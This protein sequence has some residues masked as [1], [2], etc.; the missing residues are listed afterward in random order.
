[1]PKN[2]TDQKPARR[3]EAPAKEEEKKEVVYDPLKRGPYPFS[4]VVNDIKNR[5][6]HY[7]T[8]FN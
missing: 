1:M 5:F 6:P 7:R 4:G 2:N 3:Y 8:P